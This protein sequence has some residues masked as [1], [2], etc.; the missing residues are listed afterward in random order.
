[1][2]DINQYIISKL[3]KDKKRLEA[4]LKSEVIDCDE[5]AVVFDEEKE[6]VSAATSLIGAI[7]FAERF[8]LPIDTA[9]YRHAG[10][11]YGRLAV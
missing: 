1:M 11:E 10:Q 3:D 6:I 9:N 8:K 5:F 7:R 4:A 2:T